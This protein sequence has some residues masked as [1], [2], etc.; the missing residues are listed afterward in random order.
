MAE[1]L[2]R[3]SYPVFKLN[4]ADRSWQIGSAIVGF[5]QRFSEVAMS[6]PT[7][8]M[9]RRALPWTMSSVHCQFL[10]RLMGMSDLPGTRYMVQAIFLAILMLNLALAYASSSVRPGVTRS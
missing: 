3:M 7:N 10:W 8:V 9:T 5:V 6:A 1:C 4:G 2:T